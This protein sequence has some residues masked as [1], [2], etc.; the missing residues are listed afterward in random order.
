V[1]NG[2]VVQTSATL[3]DFDFGG[4]DSLRIQNGAGISI[5]DLIDD[6]TFV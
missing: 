4:G 2:Y 5:A 3:V 6:I 1:A